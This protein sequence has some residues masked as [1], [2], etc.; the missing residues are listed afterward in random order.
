MFIKTTR[1][2]SIVLGYYNNEV[3][4]FY[5]RG[6]IDKICKYCS[7]LTDC[8]IKNTF[9]HLNYYIDDYPYIYA[10]CKRFRVNY[11]TIY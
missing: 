1:Y 7:R 11:Y 4:L 5:T 3:V 6:R 2:N 9:M 8:S 10:F